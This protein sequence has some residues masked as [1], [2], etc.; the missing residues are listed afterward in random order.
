MTNAGVRVIDN[1]NLFGVQMNVSDYKP[2]E[3]DVKVRVC[4][5]VC[6]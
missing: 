2:E 3:I 5:P 4:A 6:S 1:A